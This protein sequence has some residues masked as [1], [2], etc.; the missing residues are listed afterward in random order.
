[1]AIEGTKFTD[2]E[3]TATGKAVIEKISDADRD[4]IKEARERCDDAELEC[5]VNFNDIKTNRMFVNG[6]D[7][8]QWDENLRVARENNP[9]SPRPCLTINK[10]QTY[11]NRVCNDYRMNR[12]GMKATSKMDGVPKKVVDAAQ[13]IIRAIV[14]NGDSESAYDTALDNAATTGL[15]Y[16]IIKT[17]YVDNDSDDQ[18]IYLDRVLDP[19][20]IIFPIH[21][22]KAIDFADCEY[23]FVKKDMPKDQYEKKY[24]TIDIS[25]WDDKK[26]SK[27]IT[28]KIVRTIMYYRKKHEITTRETAGGDKREI[29]KITIEWFKLSA[30]KILA[31]GIIPGE[32]IPIVP[33]IGKEVID[34]NGKRRFKS[35]AQDSN[36]SQRMLNYWK[37]NIAEYYALA[38]KARWLVAHGQDEGYQH[39]YAA[40]NNSNII[41]LHYKPKT[42]DGIIVPPPTP[43]QQNQIAANIIEEV[44]QCDDDI[45]TTIGLPDVKMGNSKTERS[46]KAIKANQ[47]EGE[48]INYHFGD[49]QRKAMV[50]G[51]KIIC[52]MLPIVY[53]SAR[54]VKMITPTMEETTVKIN[55][56]I[57]ENGD[58]Y[59]ID[60]KALKLDVVVEPGPSYSSRKEQTADFLIELIDKVPTIGPSMIDL[61]SDAIGADQTVIDRCKML[62]PPNVQQQASMK[63]IPPAVR[64]VLQQMEQGIQQAD[65]LIKQ[66]DQLIQQLIAAVNDK[67]AEREVK[68]QTVIIKAQT[69][70]KKAAMDNAHEIASKEYEFVLNGGLNPPEDNVPASSTG[71]NKQSVSAQ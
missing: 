23:A 60:L 22:S 4:I 71:E 53:D 32:Y 31:R 3:S 61:V 35:L 41:T 63:D 50:H 62:L 58:T 65:F 46:G 34:K 28:D 48:L 11:V 40:A 64:Q 9:A 24:G 45:K 26:Q 47:K 27:W 33:D 7:G 57:T 70:L 55:Q 52:S 1:M 54:V 6:I 8:G 67:S 56:Q 39:E 37:S 42:V 36:D 68:L 25:D 12:P 5:D 29:D 14:N 20:D 13:G 21:L 43:I 17:R 19:L 16:Y 66:K 44:R 69:E 30:H 18:E 10:Q 59:S 15:G 38:P 51:W 2:V 49:N